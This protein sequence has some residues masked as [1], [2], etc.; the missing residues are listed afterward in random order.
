MGRLLG[1][2]ADSGHHEST[3]LM[4][5]E[6]EFVL[7]NESLDI[8]RSPLDR[9]NAYSMTTGLSV[10]E[11]I[12]ATLEDVSGIQVY[13]FHT[14][15]KDQLEI[16]LSPLPPMQAIDTV[17]MAQE[18]IRALALSH[19]L[20]ASISPRAVLG[21]PLSGVHAHMSV[22][23]ESLGLHF[24]AGVLKKVKPLRAF[25]LATYDSY[26]RAVGDAA[27]EWVGWET[28]NK[29]LPINQISEPRWE[30][31]FL[32]GTANIYLFIAALLVAGIDGVRQ[33]YPRESSDCN[34]AIPPSLGPGALGEWLGK[35]GITKRMPATLRDALDAARE[36]TELQGWVGP[37]PWARYLKVKETEVATFSKMTDEERRQKLLE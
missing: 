20:K 12:V 25:G 8:A 3:L 21:G 28:R 7:L 4:G 29:D 33:G 15:I 9:T 34:V 24:L 19:G 23:S 10:L 5:F 32:D 14:E 11:E 30:L 17:M 1:R 13:H 26:L 6:I 27:G 31:R 37:E 22:K 2:L 18:T 36:D 35:Y 16:A